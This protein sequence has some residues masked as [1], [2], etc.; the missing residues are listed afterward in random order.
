MGF[1]SNYYNHIAK[2]TIPLFILLK[3]NLI[4]KWDSEH[5]EIF[6][7][8]KAVFLHEHVIYHHVQGREFLLYTDTSAYDLGAKLAQ[9]DDNGKKK[10]VA[11]ASRIL[12]NAEKNNTVTERK[13]TSDTR[14][15]HTLG[16]VGIKKL[17]NTPK[18]L[19]NWPN[20]IS[21]IRE[22]IFSCDLSEG[23]TF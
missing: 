11:M 15:S 13:F 1:Y 14:D 2:I 21:I 10:T 3:K 7:Q 22:V 8:L 18:Y 4:W 9:V 6:D 20:M 17:Y 5:Q 23:Q 19:M 12:N 16:H